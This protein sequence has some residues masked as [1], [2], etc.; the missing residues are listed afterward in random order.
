MYDLDPSRTPMW[1]FGHSKLGDRWIPV[2]LPPPPLNCEPTR[3]PL[4]GPIFFRVPRVL[5][6]ACEPQRLRKLPNRVSEAL[7]S[8]FDRTRTFWVRMEII[9]PFQAFEN[10][11]DRTFRGCSLG[12]QDE[13]EPEVDVAER[14]NPWRMRRI[15]PWSDG[16]SRGAM[17]TI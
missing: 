12:Y 13:Y 10:L 4:W 8:P 15:V 16:L 17:S 5:R 11:A 2:A 1:K 3:R 9:E 14:S 6:K 7:P